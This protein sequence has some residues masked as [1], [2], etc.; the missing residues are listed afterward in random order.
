MFDNDDTVS[1]N[2]D[3]ILELLQYPLRDIVYDY[4]Q[5]V[6]D[7][8]RFGSNDETVKMY[9]YVIDN[10]DMLIEFWDFE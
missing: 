5:M 10:Y 1:W 2:D 9:K 7:C 3:D 4:N 6:K 8:G